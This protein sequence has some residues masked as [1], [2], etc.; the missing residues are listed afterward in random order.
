MLK[1]THRV[2]LVVELPRRLLAMELIRRVLELIRRLLE[3][4]RRLLELIRSQ[5]Q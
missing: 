4:T 5:Y 2:A 1:V 3:L